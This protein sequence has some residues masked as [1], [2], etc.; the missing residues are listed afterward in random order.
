MLLWPAA[1]LTAHPADVMRLRVLMQDRRADLRLTFSLLQLS[2]LLPGL[3]ANRDQGVNEAE[4]K[5]AWPRLQALLDSRVHCRV[6]DQAQG[7][8]PVLAMDLVWPRSAGDGGFAPAAQYASR[9]VD[10]EF[11]M[12]KA[13]GIADLWLGFDWWEQT[14]VQASV[15]ARFEQGEQITE[16]PFTPQEPDFLYDSGLQIP[17]PTERAGL[18]RFGLIVIGLAMALMLLWGVLK[19]LR[20]VA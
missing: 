8:G 18:K 15:Q 2:R 20:G 16:V 17:L 6:N 19:R 12:T 4:L 11:A 10:L 7:W 1:R 9:F 3:D 5:A 14:G 13:E